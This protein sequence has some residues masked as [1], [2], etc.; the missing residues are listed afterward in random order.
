MKKILFSSILVPLVLTGC[1]TT[2]YYSDYPG[3]YGPA[4]YEGPDVGIAFVGGD[5]YHHDHH[6]DSYHSSYAG[7]HASYHSSAHYAATSTSAHASHGSHSASVS[8]GTAHV[9]SGHH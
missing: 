4:Y 5:N 8:S 2:G 1:A 7:S 6:Y 9:S 3:Y